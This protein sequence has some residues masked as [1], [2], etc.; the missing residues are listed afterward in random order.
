MNTSQAVL[1]RDVM[2][3]KF[4]VI[5]GLAT[6]KQAVELMKEVKVK[7]LIVNKRHVYD[8]YGIVVISDIATKVL[9]KGRSPD[10]VC[11]YEVMTKPVVSVHPDMH[12]RYASRLLANLHLSRAPVVDGNKLVG[13]VSFTDMVLDGL[14]QLSSD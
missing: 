10:R 14:A 8:E 3:K 2:R 11:V 5:D 13:I 6:I 7:A 12:I 1:V 9:A 4:H